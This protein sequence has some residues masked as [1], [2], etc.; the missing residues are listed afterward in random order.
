[1]PKQ[2]PPPKLTPAEAQA[3]ADALIA[4]HPEI[5]RPKPK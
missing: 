3:K 2:K 5:F 1:M 4:R